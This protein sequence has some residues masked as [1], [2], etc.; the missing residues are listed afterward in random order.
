[1]PNTYKPNDQYYIRNEL[2]DIECSFLPHTES[3]CPKLALIYLQPFFLF[4][5]NEQKET[6]FVQNKYYQLF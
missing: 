3:I 1:M 6:Y 4:G 5:F 2:N